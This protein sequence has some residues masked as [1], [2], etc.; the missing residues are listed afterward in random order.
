[1]IQ[2]TSRV[3]VGEGLKKRKDKVITSIN[4]RRFTSDIYCVAFASQPDNLFDIMDAN[5]LLYPHYQNTDVKI[6]GLA[7]GKEGAT[8]L[9]KDMLMEVYNNTGAFEVRDYFA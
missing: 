3:Y 5:E 2:W 4:N 8:N 1:M 9:V 6:I 7:K